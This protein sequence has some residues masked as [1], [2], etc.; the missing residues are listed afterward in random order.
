[1]QV[2]LHCFNSMEPPGGCDVNYT[3]QYDNVPMLNA[4][5]V[6]DLMDV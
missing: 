1:M 4:R 3:P 2:S 6:E 5:Y